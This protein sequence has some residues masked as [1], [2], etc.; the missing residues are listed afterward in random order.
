MEDDVQHLRSVKAKTR[1]GA[2]DAQHRRF[3]KMKKIAGE[4]MNNAVASSRGGSSDEVLMAGIES[5]SA[6]GD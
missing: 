2:C 6:P 5:P 3:V 1:H 4:A